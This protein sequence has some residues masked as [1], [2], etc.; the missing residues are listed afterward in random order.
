[1]ED[2][3]GIMVLLVSICTKRMLQ[4]SKEK[5]F[6][7]KLLQLLGFSIVNIHLCSSESNACCYIMKT[8]RK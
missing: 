7:A 8:L 2:N 3:S 6:N 5:L 4:I 1:M